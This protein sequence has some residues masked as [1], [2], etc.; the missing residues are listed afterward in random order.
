MEDARIKKPTS[1]G[2]WKEFE[3]KVAAYF[4]AKRTPLSGMCDSITKADIIH[5]TIFVECKFRARIVFYEQYLAK[6]V[7]LQ[8]EHKKLIKT[9]PGHRLKAL[10][11]RMKDFEVYRGDLWIFD[12]EEMLQ[13]AQSAVQVS[14][15]D[16]TETRMVIM[17]SL[18][19]IEPLKAQ[20]GILD[21]YKETVVKAE[22]ENKL[23]IVTLKMKNKKGWL[24]VV[25]PKYLARIYEHIKQDNDE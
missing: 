23:P 12:K 25:D 21:L 9:I 3:R 20:K 24:F 19:T 10:V 6:Q 15:E 11:Y 8:A 4:N 18:V 1:R 7:E 13:I 5:D 17:H 22:I 2:T 14:N 16:K